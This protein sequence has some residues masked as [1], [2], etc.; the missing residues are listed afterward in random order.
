[1]MT[2]QRGPVMGFPVTERTFLEAP[3]KAFW[4]VRA[5]YYSTI[6]VS[7]RVAF[8]F[9]TC[10]INKLISTAQPAFSGQSLMGMGEYWFVKEVYIDMIKHIHPKSV[11]CI[12]FGKLY[13]MKVT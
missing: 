9:F 2:L 6:M 3:C 5:Y 1:M 11:Q 13:Y 4:F 12:D 8:L 10:Y 7:K